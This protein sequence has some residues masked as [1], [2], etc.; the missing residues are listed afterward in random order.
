M[1]SWR[2]LAARAWPPALIAPAVALAALLIAGAAGIGGY[3]LARADDPVTYTMRAGDG[4]PGYSVDLFLPE[5]I[6]IRT[7]DTV[8]WSF[9]WLEP[10]TVTLGPVTGNPAAPTHPGEDVIDFDGTNFISSGLVLGGAEIKVRFTTPGTF[11]YF[12]LIHPFMTGTVNVVDDGT[13]DTQDEVDARAGSAYTDALAGLK[14]LAAGAAAKEISVEAKADGTKRYTVAV[15]PANLDGVVMQYFPASI[16][17]NEGDS[18]RFVNDTPVPH[19]ATFGPPPN[20]IPDPEDPA[21]HDPSTPADTYDGT[22]FWNSGVIGVDWD[23]GTSFEMTFSKAGSF[24]YYCLLHEPQGQRGTVNVAAVAQEPTPTPVPPKTGSGM[25]TTGA[26]PS[27][28][29]PALIA[30]GLAVL[31]TG[32]GAIAVAVRRGR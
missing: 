25:T 3:Q 10:H 4:E 1:G 7:G 15:A 2:L 17:I 30:A 14:A 21:I 8:H 5:S 16:N 19:T 13:V 20:V 28:A 23:N 22:G 18:V 29:W 6:T 11:E 26:G 31:A 24:E 32:A 9:P 27:A 12:C